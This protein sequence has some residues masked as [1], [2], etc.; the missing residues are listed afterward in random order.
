VIFYAARKKKCNL[1]R[2]AI[3]RQ[4]LFRLSSVLSC[5]LSNLMA[6]IGGL[7]LLHFFCAVEDALKV[8]EK[9]ILMSYFL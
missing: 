6:F 4:T 1:R 2:E 8:G 9:I 3:K 7:P 5:L